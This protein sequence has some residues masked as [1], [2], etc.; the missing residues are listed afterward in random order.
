MSFSA[1]EL[2]FLILRY[3]EESGLNHTAF[4]FARETALDQLDLGNREVPSG[5]LVHVVQKGLAFVEFESKA[6]L[7]DG[8]EDDVKIGLL[9][10]ASIDPVRPRPRERTT[11]NDGAGTSGQTQRDRDR[12]ART[13]RATGGVEGRTNGGGPSQQTGTPKRDRSAHPA[14]LSPTNS[15]S[16][17]SGSGPGRGAP[18]ATHPDRSG[19]VPVVGSSTNQ[20][21]GQ[22]NNKKHAAMNGMNRSSAELVHDHGF[23]NPVRSGC[24]ISHDRVKLMRVH[25]REVFVC[26][27][28]PRRDLFCTGSSDGIAQLFDVCVDQWSPPRALETVTSSDLIPRVKT[29]NH[30]TDPSKARDVTTMDWH[31]RDDLLATGCYDGLARLWDTTGRLLKTLEAHDGP[32]LGVRFNEI[33]DRLVTAGGANKSAV[34]WDMKTLEQTQAF[35]GYTALDVDW[36]SNDKFVTCSI[37]SDL[38]VHVVGEKGGKKLKGHTSEVNVVRYDKHSDRIASCSDDMTIRV[39][40]LHADMDDALMTVVKA[41]DKAVYTIRWAP[42]GRLIASGGFDNM[43]CLWDIRTQQQIKKLE[44]HSEAVYSVNFSPDSR[45]LA[46]AGFDRTIFFWDMRTHEVVLSYSRGEDITGIFEVNFNSTGDKLSA[47]CSDGMVAVLD[48]RDLY[49][50]PTMRPKF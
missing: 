10:A 30:C 17:Q 29:L 9:D 14:G 43:V 12:E 19:G 33:G 2:N 37:D 23:Q 18:S 8:E 39:W 46:S 22:Y 7:E 13:D 26:P 34:V 5:A 38:N 27:W 11:T 6:N 1:A 48:V 35:T 32:I 41:H 44:K 50:T 15:T 47:T 49:A 20:P 24:E 28:N 25:T 16:S 31:S 36:I 4:L 45:F 42:A 21:N 3:L 40:D